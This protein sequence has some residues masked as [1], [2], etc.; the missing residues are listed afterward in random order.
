[1]KSSVQQLI[2]LMIFVLLLA[3][4]HAAPG[5]IQ[6]Q[7]TDYDPG[8]FTLNLELIVEGLSSP[9]LM[10]DPDD[11]SGRIFIVQQSGQV[12]IRQDGVILDQ[13]FLDI[14]GRLAPDRNRVF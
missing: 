10:I 11:G 9:V 6:A 4:S 13:P 5:A 3:G 12:L 14:S 8:T 1:M 2:K 7:N